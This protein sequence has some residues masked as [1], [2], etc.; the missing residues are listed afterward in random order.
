MHARSASFLFVA[1]GVLHAQATT[2]CPPR[3]Q[4]GRLNL[5]TPS[6]VAF[7]IIFNFFSRHFPLHSHRFNRTSHRHPTPG[8][9]AP[10]IQSDRN[11]SPDAFRLAPRGG[12]PSKLASAKR[13]GP[14]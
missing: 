4:I 9:L 8:P 10:P 11:R 1:I 12:R 5:P 6:R 7:P 13:R 3:A 2:A 14:Q